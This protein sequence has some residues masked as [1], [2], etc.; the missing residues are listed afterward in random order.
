MLASHIA[1]RAFAS[2]L[3]GRDEK[4]RTAL[5][6]L[7][8]SFIHVHSALQGI[9][10][11][12]RPSLLEVSLHIACVAHIIRSKPRRDPRVKDAISLFCALGVV[13][14]SFEMIHRSVNLWIISMALWSVAF[15]VHRRRPFGIHSSSVFHVLLAGPEVC[16]LAALGRTRTVL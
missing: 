15:T 9:S 5:Y 13:V 11:S 6:K 14:S 1:Q 4:T 8:A 16:L 3:L 10:W 2:L 7:D 12:M